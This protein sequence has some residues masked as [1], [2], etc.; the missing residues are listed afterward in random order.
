MDHRPETD[1]N[2]TSRLITVLWLLEEEDGR[3]RIDMQED[4][5]H[6][7][8]RNPTDTTSRSHHFSRFFPKGVHG[9]GDA[10]S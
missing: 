3:L 4:F 1:F 5:Y 7:D 8:V 9:P 2:A 6:P 10:T